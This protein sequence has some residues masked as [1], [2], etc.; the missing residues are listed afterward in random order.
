MTTKPYKGTSMEG[1]IATWYA[2]ITKR[3]RAYAALAHA[4]AAHV[5]PGAR[6]L[7]VAPGPGYLAIEMARRGLRVSG[8]D[9]S[10]TF[11]RIARDEARTAGV[12]VDFREGNASQLPYPD[13]S[14]DFVLCRA[15]F[16]NFADPL[17]ALDEAHRVL[18]PG[19]QAS[20]I[21]LRKEASRED[22]AAEVATMQLSWLNAL[23]TRL[24]FRFLLLGRAY[25]QDAIRELAARSRFGGGDVVRDGI[26]F[27]L[28]LTKAEA[29]DQLPRYGNS[30]R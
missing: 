14:F 15:A 30:T 10:K 6:V 27:E 20:I 8:I 11:V 5:P 4:I 16:K 28:R 21:D 29:A 3:D 2:R 12:E 19:G 26:A 22:I 13:G 25:T 18:A 9:I 7:E 17:G 24:T 23:W 1:P